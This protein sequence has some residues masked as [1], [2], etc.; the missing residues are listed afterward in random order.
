MVE[1]T[2]FE[3]AA[4]S[5][6]T[7]RATKL[8]YTSPHARKSI[9]NFRRIVYNV[10]LLLFFRQRQVLEV[11]RSSPFGIVGDQVPVAGKQVLV[12]HEAVKADRPARVQFARTDAYF[13]SETIPEPIRET[14]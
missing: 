8:R 10:F 11:E 12:G 4:S 6:R 2:R 13:R 1:V 14:R 5:S 3:L 9:H 7:K